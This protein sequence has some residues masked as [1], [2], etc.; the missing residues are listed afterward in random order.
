MRNRR[1]LV[2]LAL[3]LGVGCAALL[4]ML[5]PGRTEVATGTGG[6]G[7]VA[8]KVVA[9]SNGALELGGLLYKPA[10]DG[11]FPTILY[12][13]GS[14]GGL[15]NNQ[16]FDAIAPVF[17]AHG[18]AFFAPYRRG[19]GLSADAGPYIMDEIA[20]ARRRGG[21]AEAD[22]TMTRLLSTEHLGDQLAAYAWLRSQP[23]VRTNAI[24]VMGNSFGGV[25]TLLGAANADYCAAVDA[26]GGAE[27]WEK[28][29]ALRDLLLQSAATAAT[30]T[31]F[32]QA[33]NDFNLAPSEALHAARLRAGLRSELRVY[34]AFGNS[35]SD[36]HSFAYRAV[37]AWSAD[38][39]AFLEQHCEM[40]N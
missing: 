31:L 40:Q 15:L 22:K 30:P 9:F 4:A 35:P 10:G 11:P 16:A 3:G 38:V 19:Q 7:S 2:G 18:W 37:S 32:F 13:H 36:G 20:A 39:M 21:L 34:P 25:E 8:A 1:T 12:N 29:P 5:M 17:V 28:A 14:A 24:A 27:S 26:A 6:T 33:E 23:F